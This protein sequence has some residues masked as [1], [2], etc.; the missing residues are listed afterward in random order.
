MKKQMGQAIAAAAMAGALA[1]CTASTDR[2]GGFAGD[3]DRA[4]MGMAMKAQSALIEG[5][6]VAAVGLAERAVETNPRDVGYRTLLGNAYFAA[7]RFASAEAAYRDSLELMPAQPQVILKK[8]LVEIAQ[9]KS[10]QALDGL[11]QARGYVNAADLGLAVALAGRP[12]VAVDLLTT[13]ARS[14]QADARTR[15]NLALAF[16]MTGD[17]TQARTIASQD[18]PAD[19][20]EA[21]LQSWMAMANPEHPS[22]AVAALTGVTPAQADPGQPVAL[23]LN[24]NADQPRYAALAP[25]NVAPAP[26][27]VAAPLPAPVRTAMA[28]RVALDD[29]PV[30]FTKSIEI[31]IHDVALVEADAAEVSRE[32]TVTVAALDVDPIAPIALLARAAAEVKAARST[33]AP[34]LSTEAVRLTESAGS[35]RVKAVAAEEASRSVV[36]LASYHDRDLLDH[37]WAIATQRFGALE[38]F[39]PMAA[40]F[41]HDGKTFYRLAAHGFASDADARSFCTE[42]KAA[43][44][45]C[46]VRK[47]AGD[48]PFNRKG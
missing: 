27:P 32:E 39:Q 43:G 46:F 20:L 1:A 13:A 5:D 15:Q 9:G 18:V 45:D 29:A 17:W 3:V 25:Q 48:T 11:E 2:V 41:R 38:A 22:H 34:G 23:A 36:Q 33:A 47:M 26:A 24:R 35:L 37:G 6:F 7:G 40:R 42:V 30:S 4:N 31:P 8:A 14:P 44:V 21:R 10:A 12:Q 28:P 19:E 16:A